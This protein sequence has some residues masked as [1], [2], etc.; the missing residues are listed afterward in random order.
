MG[1][2]ET[3]EQVYIQMFITP[4]ML[5]ICLK[6]SERRLIK[7]YHIFPRDKDAICGLRNPASVKQWFEPEHA[8]N[9]SKLNSCHSRRV[10][11]GSLWKTEQ[12]PTSHWETTTA[13]LRQWAAA[14]GG[15][16]S[17]THCWWTPRRSQSAWSSSSNLC[18][19]VCVRSRC[20][21]M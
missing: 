6:N 19:F 5:S 11:R 10:Q 2:Y 7:R 15:M 17:S 4:G 12:R 16:A 13:A 21:F 1:T 8:S 9:Q 20:V 3:G 18:V 14:R